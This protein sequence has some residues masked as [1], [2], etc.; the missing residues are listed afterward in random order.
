VTP[1]GSTPPGRSTP[2]PGAGAER[3]GPGR[4]QSPPETGGRDAGAVK[5][6]LDDLAARHALPTGAVARLGLLLSLLARDS[7]APTA[8]RDPGRAVDRHVADSLVA[9][10]LRAVRE[11]RTMADVGSGAG[12]PGL[13]LATAKPDAAVRLVEGSSR[14][15]GFLARAVRELDLERVTVVNSR[16]EQWREGIAVHDLVVS[17]AVASLPVVLEYGAPLLR[18]GGAL[19]LWRGAPRP[20]ELEAGAA[21]A[22]ILGLEPTAQLPVEPFPDAQQRHLY[23]YLKVR[24]TPPRFPRRPGVAAKRPLTQP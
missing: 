9:L 19:V 13:P 18:L 6:R 16:V 10:D 20:G 14:A 5:H 22:S 7:H 15:S 4:G 3:A 1:G 8:I 23:L 21:A 17:R 12:F 11:A 24:D 2:A